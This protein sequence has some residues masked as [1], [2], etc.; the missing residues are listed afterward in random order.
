MSFYSSG[1]E[2]SPNEAKTIDEIIEGSL[3]RLDD[4]TLTPQEAK[5]LLD[6][7]LHQHAEISGDGDLDPEDIASDE[8]FALGE[9]AQGDQERS[10][11]EVYRGYHV[12]SANAPLVAGMPETNLAQ[13]L[14]DGTVWDEVAHWQSTRPSA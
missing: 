14:A 1:S 11:G 12:S 13:E 7:R 10:F 4:V 6:F 8:M 3:A 2:P 9:I 5:L